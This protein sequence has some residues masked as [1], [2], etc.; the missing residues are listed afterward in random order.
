MCDPSHE[1]PVKVKVLFLLLGNYFSVQCSTDSTYLIPDAAAEE[2]ILSDLE[3]S[4]KQDS[5]DCAKRLICELYGSSETLAWDERLIKN[6][7]QP[8]L[9]YASPI[10]QFQLAADLGRR[11]VSACVTVYSR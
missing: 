5:E 11:Q 3:S 8:V 4:N 7:I 10:I 2:E 1:H 9:D 6:Y